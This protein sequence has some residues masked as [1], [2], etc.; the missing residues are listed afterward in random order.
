MLNSRVAAEAAKPLLTKREYGL[1]YGAQ[2]IQSFYSD[3]LDY[4]VDQQTILV[5]SSDSYVP[6]GI[7]ASLSFNAKGK[8]EHFWLAG[9]LVSSIDELV[10]VLKQQTA[11][12]TKNQ[13]HQKQS[14]DQQKQN[15]QSSQYIASVL[16]LDRREREQLEG[17]LYGGFKQSLQMISFDNKT[18]EKAVKGKY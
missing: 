11:E 13:E 5:G 3:E 17:F 7:K 6:K 12:Y 1:Q 16:N 14:F 9:G 2:Y 8:R 10:H 18:M 15:K 4:A